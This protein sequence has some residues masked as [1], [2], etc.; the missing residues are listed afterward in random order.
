MLS[1]DEWQYYPVNIQ[2]SIFWWSIIFY[3]E[4]SFTCVW[5]KNLQ[6]V[7]LALSFQFALVL[8]LLRFLFKCFPFQSIVTSLGS[9]FFFSVSLPDTR[10]QR[11][12]KQ[13]NECRLTR[14]V[15][16][17]IWV[18]TLGTPKEKKP[19]ETAMQQKNFFSLRI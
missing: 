11:R 8:N 9:I 12:F 1:D 2:F 18:R 17:H 16:C 3:F 4:G 14:H 10:I 7:Y 19:I 13:L 6:G 5:K 15:H